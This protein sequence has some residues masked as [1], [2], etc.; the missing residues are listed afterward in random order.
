MSTDKLNTYNEINRALVTE[1]IRCSPDSWTSGT[2][3]IDCD[4]T[5]IDYKLKNQD[6]SEKAQISEG[7]AYLC[8]Q[9]YVVMR[10]NGDEWV[11]ATFNFFQEDGEWRLNG[12]FD[13]ANSSN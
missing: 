2:L 4:G 9:L 6:A 11:R 13:Y 12:N 1:A 7:L 10:D 8:E 3:T 5:R